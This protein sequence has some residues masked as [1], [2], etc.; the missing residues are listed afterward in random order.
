MKL[1]CYRHKE[2]GLF[3]RP[4][5]HILVRGVYVKSNLSKTPKFYSKRYKV[6]N[7]IGSYN[8]HIFMEKFLKDVSDEDI[9]ENRFSIKNMTLP[10]KEEDW[11]ILDQNF[12][13]C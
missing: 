2:T 5:R 9:R 10:A 1:Y 3:Y 7:L 12:E 6:E 11:E 13:P 4:V 8:S